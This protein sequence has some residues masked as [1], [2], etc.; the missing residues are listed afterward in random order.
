[1][2]NR[3]TA[4][5]IQLKL[6]FLALL[7]LAGFICSQVISVMMTSTIQWSTGILTIATFYYFMTG[8]F[9]YIELEKVDDTF[10]IK[11][12]N[13]FPFNRSFKMYKIPISS[14]IKYDTTG[15]RIY[16]KK[17]HLYQMSASQ[18]AKYP[19]IFISALSKKDEENMKT[20]FSQLKNKN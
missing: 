19:P 16:K 18:L 8:G 9:Y 13:S 10:E 15:N 3:K 1:M 20:F 4:G 11:F 14:F 2:N 5:S 12:Y 7:F 17:L 6:T